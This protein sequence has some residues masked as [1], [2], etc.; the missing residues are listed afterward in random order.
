MYT[1]SVCD[2][3][4][5]CAVCKIKADESESLLPRSFALTPPPLMPLQ[6]VMWETR[7][8]QYAARVARS[9]GFVGEHDASERLHPV[10]IE[11]HPEQRHLGRCQIV[12]IEE[13]RVR[14]NGVLLVSDALPRRAPSLLCCRGASKPIHD[15]HNGL[16]QVVQKSLGVEKHLVVCAPPREP[17]RCVTGALPNGSSEPSNPFE[18]SVRR[19]PGTPKY[20]G[21]RAWIVAH[22][23]VQHFFQLVLLEHASVVDGSGLCGI[24]TMADGARI[25]KPRAQD[26]VVKLRHTYRSQPSGM[27][28]LPPK[29]AH[30]RQN[31]PRGCK[32]VSLVSVDDG[33]WPIP[34]KF[35]TDAEC[36]RLVGRPVVVRRLVEAVKY[37]SDL[38]EVVAGHAIP[39]HVTQLR[40]RYSLCRRS[41]LSAVGRPPLISCDITRHRLA[42]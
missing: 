7:Q 19:T 20:I 18:P 30:R 32:R 1:I 9:G 34:T 21:A 26:P 35:F 27:S 16:W 23:D 31:E 8:P 33:P 17:V 36:A 14:L 39:K 22:R 4:I 6:P 29:A 11:I 15:G 41:A 24:A 12:R 5:A 10:R 40:K 25:R 2:A 3:R 38:A 42:T 28:T 37:E 13:D